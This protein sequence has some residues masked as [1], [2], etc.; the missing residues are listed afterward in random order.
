[1]TISASDTGPIVGTLWDRER[2]GTR[3]PSAGRRDE[4]QLNTV[5]YVLSRYGALSGTD[6]EHLTRSELPWQLANA[7]RTPG[8][9]TR[10]EREWMRDYFRG[11]GAPA[12]EPDDPAL[13]D[14]GAVATLLAGAESRRGG[15]VEPDSLADIRRL[16]DGG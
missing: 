3:P 9:T 14:S 7:S 5:G 2:H 12:A 11:P 10:I 8:S 6:L 4:G 1:M 13:L 15:P 16:I